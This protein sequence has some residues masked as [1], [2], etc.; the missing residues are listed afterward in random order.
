MN[1]NE[2][3]KVGKLSKEE[4]IEDMWMPWSCIYLEFNSGNPYKHVAVCLEDKP[5]SVLSKAVLEY[6][7]SEAIVV[8]CLGGRNNGCFLRMDKINTWTKTTRKLRGGGNKS[9]IQETQVVNVKKGCALCYREQNSLKN[10][11]KKSLWKCALMQ[12]KLC[13][14]FGFVLNQ[15]H[16]LT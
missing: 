14:L 10:K 2:H 4:E 11:Q 9:D 6:S 15:K 16:S 13:H 12:L 7:P 5:G 1:K 8:S 3:I